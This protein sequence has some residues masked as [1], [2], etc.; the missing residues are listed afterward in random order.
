VTGPQHAALAGRVWCGFC[1]AD[2]GA[3]CRTD[4]GLHFARYLR[5]YRRGLI[6][7]DAIIAVCLAIPAVSHG[8]VVPEVPALAAIRPEA[9]IARDR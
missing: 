6:S 8:Q 3:P 1:W 9:A 5:A 2:P 7:A 4:G